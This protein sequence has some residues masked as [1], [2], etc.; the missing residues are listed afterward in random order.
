MRSPPLRR[1]TTYEKHDLVQSG[2]SSLT[3]WPDV[4]LIPQTNKHSCVVC[5]EG[6]HQFRDLKIHLA[7]HTAKLAPGNGNDEHVLPDSDSDQISSMAASSHDK[8]NSYPCSEC[9][10]TLY[11]ASLL[12]N[13]LSAHE[14]EGKA[15]VSSLIDGTFL[16]NLMSDITPQTEDTER[17]PCVCLHCGQE[18][19]HASQLKEHSVI[20]SLVC[21]ICPQGFTLLC[22]LKKHLRMHHKGDTLYT[23]CQVCIQGFSHETDLEVHMDSHVKHLSSSVMCLVIDELS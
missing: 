22:E 20:Q 1:K 4:K 11:S 3:S 6:S 18:F 7:N 2:K 23:S 21:P 13:H 19:S 17:S 8:C 14:Q 9:G 10:V 12:K 16:S 15:F 5:G